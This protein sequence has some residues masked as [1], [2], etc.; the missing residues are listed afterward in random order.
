MAGVTGIESGPKDSGGSGHSDEGRNRRMAALFAGLAF[1]MVGM[2]YAAVPLYEVFCQV[3]G[4][5]GT[6]QRVEL[7][8]TSVGTRL[9]KIRF[10]AAV[11]RDMAWDFRPE[12]KVQELKVGEQGLAYYEAYNPTNKRI[13][14]R[15]TYNVSPFKAGSYF[16]KVEC[17]CFTEQVLEPGQRVSMPVLYYIEPDIEED[18]YLDDVSEITLSYTFFAVEDDGTAPESY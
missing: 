1:A 11:H 13:V 5:G 15:A 4:Y 3:T 14:G 18:R 8:S 10:N 17:F 12:Q 9:M 7:A 16:A 2:A 6:T